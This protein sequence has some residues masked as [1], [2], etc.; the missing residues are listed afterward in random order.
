MKPQFYDW[1]LCISTFK[2]IS[3]LFECTVKLRTTDTNYKD[4]INVRFFSSVQT[5]LKNLVS[6]SSKSEDLWISNFSYLSSLV[7]IVG[8]HGTVFVEPIS[9]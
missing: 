5:F 3:K 6:R 4:Y 2:N 7:C 1:E 8:G 9:D